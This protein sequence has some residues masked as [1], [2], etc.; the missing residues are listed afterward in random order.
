[1]NDLK[2]K[3]YNHYCYFISLK[4]SLFFIERY[5]FYMY[6]F[7]IK[8]YDKHK[9]INRSFEGEKMTQSLTNKLEVVQKAYEEDNA[10]QFFTHMPDLLD[11]LYEQHRIEEYI[12]YTMHCATLYFRHR[13][14]ALASSL[15]S[16]K[17]CTIEEHAIPLQKIR[18]YNLL[19]ALQGKLAR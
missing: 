12:T 18:Y 19:A 14:L 1:M 4:I 5:A 8:R 13:N 16:D 10:S 2:Q 11:E 17:S 15:L 7:H 9:E 3:I 6:F